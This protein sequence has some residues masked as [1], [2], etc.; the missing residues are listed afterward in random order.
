MTVVRGKGLLSVNV[1]RI[2]RGGEER[3]LI[4]VRRK[5]RVN[6]IERG[7]ENC[8]GIIIIIICNF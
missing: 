3:E 7:E 5:E 8:I 1:K 2:C 6:Q 4:G